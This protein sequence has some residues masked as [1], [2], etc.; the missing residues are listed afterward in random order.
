MRIKTDHHDAHLAIMTCDA[1][2][3]ESRVSTLSPV[4][5]E[6]V[7]AFA[8]LHATC[9]TQGRPDFDAAVNDIEAGGPGAARLERMMASSPHARTTPT[10]VE[11]VIR[12]VRKFDPTAEID[13]TGLCLHQS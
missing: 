8:V 5:T 13:L 7:A 9:S 12:D 6:L 1:C 3:M 10:A 4:F 11:A 2:M